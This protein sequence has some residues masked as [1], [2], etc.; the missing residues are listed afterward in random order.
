MWYLLVVTILKHNYDLHSDYL[1]F[2]V[3]FVLWTPLFLFFLKD[4]FKLSFFPCTIFLWMWMVK[5][6]SENDQFYVIL[7]LKLSLVT[8]SCSLESIL[9]PPNNREVN[10]G[11]FISCHNNNFSSHAIN[12]P[13]WFDKFLILKWQDFFFFLDNFLS[14][15][16]RSNNVVILQIV[17][18]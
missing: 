6:Y 8:L 14:F 7:A 10:S 3:S 4:I 17:K 5:L 2:F 11:K 13:E 18:V 12:F 16:E 15:L 1:V 9:V